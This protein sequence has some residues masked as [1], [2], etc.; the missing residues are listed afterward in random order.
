MCNP[1]FV[2]VYGYL[3]LFVYYLPQL[4]TCQKMI[5]FPLVNSTT[6]NFSI[7]RG[8]DGQR[9]QLGYSYV[10]N[11]WGNDHILADGWSAAWQ[12]GSGWHLNIQAGRHLV[13]RSNSI[14]LILILAQRSGSELSYVSKARERISFRVPVLNILYSRYFWNWGFPFTYYVDL[15]NKVNLFSI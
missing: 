9:G 7:V 4:K 15:P 6:S 3:C 5:L 1:W 10:Q 13:S 2:S 11:E 8:D 12:S 14:P